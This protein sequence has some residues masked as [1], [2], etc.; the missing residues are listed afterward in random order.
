MQSKS[1]FWDVLETGKRTIAGLLRISGELVGT[2]GE[3]RGPAKPLLRDA[4]L[5]CGPSTG[6]SQPQNTLGH[7]MGNL[8]L[9]MSPVPVDPE[10][11]FAGA[12]R[13]TAQIE[14]ASNSTTWPGR[15][16]MPPLLRVLAPGDILVQHIFVEDKLSWRCCQ[17]TGQPSLHSLFGTLP[18]CLLAF[19]LFLSIRETADH[20]PWR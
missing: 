6:R 8:M 18:D 13:S 14:E 20:E 11:T 19:L 2:S 5:R 1:P 17:C 15:F 12:C 4:T 10:H 9:D 16:Q 3:A 7:S